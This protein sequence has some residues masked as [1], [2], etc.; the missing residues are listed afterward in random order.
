MPRSAP[1]ATGRDAA[2]HPRDRLA[3][4]PSSSTRS[5]RVSSPGATR[6]STSV[7]CAALRLRRASRPQAVRRAA[8][9]P[10]VRK[11]GSGVRRRRVV[12]GVDV[13]ASMLA[14]S[15]IA[16]PASAPRP[17][18]CL[19]AVA[20][21]LYASL[22]ARGGAATPPVDDG[23]SDD[24][25]ILGELTTAQV[26]VL[27][28]QSARRRCQPS[29]PGSGVSADEDDDEARQRECMRLYAECDQRGADSP[30]WQAPVVLGERATPDATRGRPPWPGLRRE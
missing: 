26:K 30:R 18:R 5:S 1:G 10:H 12:V 14:N 29:V 9:C 20:C 11:A 17:A 27:V 23:H 15:G 4:D 25:E 22:D 8:R 3:V 6:S 21:L 7:M 19:P 24:A 2:S 28:P 13:V 16:H